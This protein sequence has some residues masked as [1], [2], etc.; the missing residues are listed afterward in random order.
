MSDYET[1]ISDLGG[2][3]PAQVQ[4]FI[5]VSMFE[6][7]VA[8]AL[9][10]HP[11][12]AARTPPWTCNLDDPEHTMGTPT[13]GIPSNVTSNTRIHGNCTLYDDGQCSNVEY[14]EYTSI[15]SEVN[16]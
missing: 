10:V 8:W 1:V 13:T 4:I 5:L 9:L 15:V 12:F 7:P 3:G 2:F 6:T 11:V 14:G 16:T